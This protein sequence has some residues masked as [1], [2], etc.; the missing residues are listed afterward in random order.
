MTSSP[1]NSDQESSLIAFLKTYQT[2]APPPC[3]DLEDR[4]M[5][6]LNPQ[7]RSARWLWIPS[8]I[9]LLA[10]LSWSLIP[11]PGALTASEQAE[12]E[13]FLQSTWIGVTEDVD[14][15]GFSL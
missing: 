11:R 4:I 6:A 10:A 7:P 12:L 14:L 13:S 5:A 3:P 9:G 15:T 1:N 8:L 2:P